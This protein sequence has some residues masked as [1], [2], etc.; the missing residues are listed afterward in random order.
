[1]SRSVF[2][3]GFGQLAYR[4]SLRD[5]ITCLDVLKAKRFH[6]G[7]RG[8]VSRSTLADANE[9]RDWRIY[10]DSTGAHGTHAGTRAL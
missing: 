10:A 7:I 4:E 9:R 2:L 3:H 5:V 1:M 8:T 6:A